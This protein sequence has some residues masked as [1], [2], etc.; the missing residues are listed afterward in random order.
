MV[1]ERIVM[2]LKQSSHFD[3]RKRKSAISNEIF[4]L[5]IIKSPDCISIAC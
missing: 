2:Y 4:Y 1:S 5:F 3:V